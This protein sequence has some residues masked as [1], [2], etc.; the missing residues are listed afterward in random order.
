M[1]FADLVGT[2]ILVHTN[3]TGLEEQVKGGTTAAAELTEPGGIWVTHPGLSEGLGQ[4]AGTGA[5][6]TFRDSTCH[7]FL[8]FSSIVF[9][10]ARSPV[11]DEGSLGLEENS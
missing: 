3:I 10:A 11:L 1:N 8:P 6:R 9:V 5:T 4:L 7:V 2:K